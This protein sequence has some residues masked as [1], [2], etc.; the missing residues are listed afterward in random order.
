MTDETKIL[1]GSFKGVPISIEPGTLSGGRKVAISQFP[2]R[3]TQNVED[4]GA[5]PRKYQLTIIINDKIN[6]DYFS[7]RDRLLQALDGG[8]SGPLIHPLYGRIEGVVA[9]SYSINEN[10]SE[11]GS[12]TI[13]VDFEV[14]ENIGIPQ[15]SENVTTQIVAANDAVQAA[16]QQNIEDNFSVTESLLGSFDAAIDTVGG[17]ID[18]IKDSTSFIGDIADTINNYSAEIGELSAD[19]NSLV[20]DPLRL[21]SA[22]G[23]IME[24]VNGLDA[25][26]ESTLDTFTKFFDFDQDPVQTTPAGATASTAGLLEQSRNSGTINSFAACSSL[27]YAYVAASRYQYRTTADID[28]ITRLLD[29]QYQKVLNGSGSQKMK[30]TITD[31]RILTLRALDEVRVVTRK[32]VTVETMPTAARLLSFDLYGSDDDAELIIDL[33]SITDVSFIEGAQQVVAGE[34]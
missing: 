11:F 30:D 27:G 20:T 22:L 31:L 33:N 1:S 12:T 15:A 14:T 3:D 2:N 28:R 13:S 9:V 18:E 8:G 25:S 4:L 34:T 19:I 29:D 10:F 32:I 24:T 21:A 16:A 7:Y 26:I 23:G 5:Q 17:F 6:E